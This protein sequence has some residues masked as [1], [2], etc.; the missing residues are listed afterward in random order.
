MRRDPSDVASGHHGAAGAQRRRRTVARPADASPSGSQD[1]ESTRGEHVALVGRLWPPGAPARGPRLTAGRTRGTPRLAPCASPPTNRPVTRRVP[2]VRSRR[3]L[4]RMI[5]RPAT[6]TTPRG[7]LR[8]GQTAPPPS[9]CGTAAPH[10][11]HDGGPVH[12]DSTTLV[13]LNDGPARSH[14]RLPACLQGTKSQASIS[15]SIVDT[16]T[17]R[18]LGEAIRRCRAIPRQSV[19]RHFSHGGD[20]RTGRC[21]RM[22]EDDLP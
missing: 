4:H 13:P 11:Q 3:R 5:V 16:R 22:L 12:I 15:S 6:A 8:I 19:G 7:P 14:P 18:L 1:G 20:V 21:V 2:I 9:R 10:L 17:C